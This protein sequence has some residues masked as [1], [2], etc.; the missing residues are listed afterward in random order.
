MATASDLAVLRGRSTYKARARGLIRTCNTPYT[1]VV[2]AKMQD[3]RP[4]PS[5]AKSSIAFRNSSGMPLSVR[6]RLS[7]RRRILSNSFSFVTCR[8]GMVELGVC[9]FF[10][11]SAMESLTA[12]VSLSY[13]SNRRFRKRWRRPQI[14]QFCGDDRRIR[15]GPRPNL[16][17]HTPYT[18]VVP[19]KM[20]DLRAVTIFYE[21]VFDE[22]TKFTMD[23]G[24]IS[25]GWFL[26]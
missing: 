9:F 22:D 1:S 26:K 20:Q 25:S 5:F 16:D 13:P 14:L 23:P 19:A 24:L 2:P 12:P 4:S 7:T 21:I 3:L 15:Q 10:L 6:K 17:M 11:T 18:S 8:D